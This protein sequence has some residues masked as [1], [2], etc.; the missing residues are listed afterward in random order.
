MAA[1][2]PTTGDRLEIMSASQDARQ[3][4]RL[5]CKPGSDGPPA[6]VLSKLLFSGLARRDSSEEVEDNDDFVLL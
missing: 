1:T 2:A 3:V 6:L 5:C 4:R